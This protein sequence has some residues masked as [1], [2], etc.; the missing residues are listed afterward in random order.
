MSR[1]A[2]QFAMPSGIAVKFA[3]EVRSDRRGHSLLEKQVAETDPT[4]R[5]DF[6]RDGPDL[7]S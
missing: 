4:T 2:L 5:R 7:D 1:E 6:R 3:K